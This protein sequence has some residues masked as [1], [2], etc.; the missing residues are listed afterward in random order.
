MIVSCCAFLDLRLYALMCVG[1]VCRIVLGGSVFVFIV[2]LVYSAG[3]VELCV[4]DGNGFV[5]WASCRLCFFI[6]R[7][8]TFCSR[9]WSTSS[10]PPALYRLL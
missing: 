5:V 10:V 4:V 1:D 8:V 9:L 3:V 6:F 2:L 7:F